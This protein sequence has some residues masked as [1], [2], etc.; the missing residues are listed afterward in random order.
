MAEGSG[1]AGKA[2]AAPTKADLCAL[3]GKI[4]AMEADLYN[5]LAALIQ[6]LS[7]QISQLNLSVQATAKLAEGA[8]D[9]CVA[10]NEDIRSLQTEAEA[11][12]ERLAIVSNRQ[13]FFNLKFR[14]LHEKAEQNTALK[15]L[16]ETW[17]TDVLQI[18]EQAVPI[19]T[20]AYRVG[21]PNVPTRPHPRDIVVTFTSIETKHRVLDLAKDKGHLIFGEDRVQV[22]KDLAPEALAK[23]RELKEIIAI[24]KDVNVG[25]RWASPIKLQLF[26]KGKSYFIRSEEEGFDILQS[27]GIATPMATERA[28]AKR[29]LVMHS[30]PAHASKKT[31]KTLGR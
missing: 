3:G 31:H 28:S 17:L 6:P 20:Q 22:F 11:Q 2:A 8:M 30:P 26:Y 9:M 1:D 24:L 12:A 23:K 29:K 16:M 27:L 7:E 14:G 15:A 5:K 13:R 18:R 19:T 10:Q 4:E 21:R 25:H